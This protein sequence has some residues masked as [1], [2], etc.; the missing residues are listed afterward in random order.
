MHLQRHS[1]RRLIVVCLGLLLAAGCSREPDADYLASGRDFLQRKE[2]A[3]ALIQLRNAA[4][5]DPEHAETRYL[6]GLALRGTANPLSAEVELRRALDLGHTPEQVL[7]MLCRSLLETA[8]FDKV[9]DLAASR[10]V[11][12]AAARAELKALW[13]EALVAKGQAGPARRLY[14]EALA[15]D[16]TNATARL[17]T[18]RLMA[19]S[20]QGAEAA[21]TVDAVI[22]AH[23]DSAEAWALRAGL[24]AREARL[25]EAVVAYEKAVELQPADVRSHLALVP[26]LLT[27]NKVDRAAEVQ[28]RLAKLVPSAPGTIYLDALVASAKGEG[29]RARTSI[30]L[31]LRAA[32][33]D[34]RIQLLAG[35]IEYDLG[36]HEAAKRLLQR[37]VDAVPA[38]PRAR[39]LL[40]AS[41]LQLGEVALAERTI[42]PLLASSSA[43]GRDF[44]LAAEVAQAAGDSKKALARIEQAVARETENPAW[45]VAL[46]R[47]LFASGQAG[48]GVAELEAVV[49]ADPGNTV[50]DALLVEHFLRA[51]QVDRAAA[52]ATTALQ[53]LPD[54]A[55]GH[56]L[57]GLVRRAQ[58]Q[59]PAAREQ[60]EKALSLTPDFP[61]AARNLASM[62]L[63]DGRVDAAQERYQALVAANPR[64]PQAALLLAGVMRR[65]GKPATEVVAVV[66][67]ALE[68]N[69]GFAPLHLAKVDV[70]M[71]SGDR[72]AALAAATA[73]QAALPR[74]ARVGYVL[75]RVQQSAGDLGQAQASLGRLSGEHPNTIAPHLALAEIQ[76]MEQQWDAARASVR[77]ALALR[78]DY[79]PG[80]M[81]LV[82]IAARAGA[83]DEAMTAAR[84][85]QTRWPRSGA[86]H[87][88]EASVLAVRQDSAGAEKVLRTGLAA[89]GDPALA[90]TLHRQLLSRDRGAEADREVEAWLA[91]TPGAPVGVL[92]AVG[93]SWQAR[94]D[95]RRAADW[96]RRAVDASPK[97]VVALNNLAWELGQL[98]NREALEIARRA[99]A[100]APRS[101]PVLDTMGVLSLQ[102]GEPADGV[103]HLEQAVQ[104]APQVP[105][106]RVNLA[107]ALIR[108]GRKADAGRQLDEATRLT[109]EGKPLP[110]IE[111]LRRQI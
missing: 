64:D 37:V 39:Q 94:Q 19:A 58:G 56:N 12:D 33:D 108:T 92:L 18:A 27:L 78:P 103:R 35:S 81:A 84:A 26:M 59:R 6:L 98:G 102:F 67:R 40:A 17:G 85:I 68:G 49:R 2:F 57:L 89:S 16:A 63:E 77:R 28:K 62:D 74:D 42:A 29:E 46:A 88:A 73:A 36:N 82:E 109:G 47:L 48:R 8:Q 55:V 76:V 91:R 1:T 80:H 75:A 44:A 32:P 105:G 7:P 38:E 41:Q 83:F 65:G 71:S 106:F 54:T 22:A 45:R 101:A 53:R 60:F 52:V 97:D 4:G 21:A 104:Q 30:Q 96:Y 24:L 93:D 86:G 100:Q 95:H 69:R 9:I 10:Q 5:R 90:V 20:D 111:E 66:D 3:S 31:A 72:Q 13:A 99:L 107:R 79:L 11:G 14:E 87:A 70:L 15:L 25:P 110:E 43:G 34:L 61:A 50:A 23:P 51:R